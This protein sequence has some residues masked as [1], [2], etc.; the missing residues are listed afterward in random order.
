MQYYSKMEM[1]LSNTT[2]RAILHTAH[3][4]LNKKFISCSGYNFINEK[5]PWDLED[6]KLC[7]D[8]RYFP[9]TE[10]FPLYGDVCCCFT[11]N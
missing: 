4:V 9:F 7:V 5:R 6:Q 10:M 3:F 2:P 8:R 1:T 11:L